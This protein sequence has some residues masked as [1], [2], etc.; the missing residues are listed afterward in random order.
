[1]SKKIPVKPNSTSIISAETFEIFI[2]SLEERCFDKSNGS[3]SKLRLIIDSKSELFE[4]VNDSYKKTKK[5]FKV[6][7][8]DKEGKLFK[9]VLKNNEVYIKKKK[10][11]DVENWYQK[12]DG[13]KKANTYFDVTP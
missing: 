9:L 12:K 5:G 4:V 13:N 6:L 3:T 2:N 8:K 11:T 1:M 10:I 7:L